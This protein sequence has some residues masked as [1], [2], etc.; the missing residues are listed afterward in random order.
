[1]SCVAVRKLRHT[2]V[3]KVVGF[4]VELKRGSYKVHIITMNFDKNKTNIESY[5]DAWL[6][7][8]ADSLINT[9]ISKLT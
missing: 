7:G 2:V 9:V 8:E 6:V 1:M 4:A 5:P 3:N